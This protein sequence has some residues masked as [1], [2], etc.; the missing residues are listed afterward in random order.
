LLSDIVRVESHDERNSSTGSLKA[1]NTP[2]EEV[3]MGN[4]VFEIHCISG[5]VYYVGEDLDSSSSGRGSARPV[6]SG[7]GLELAKNWE[8]AIR[9]ARLPLSL[10]QTE[11]VTTNVPIQS[12][13]GNG[14]VKSSGS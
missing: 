6:Q 11:T 5:T 4:Y 10:S 14:Q 3:N 13:S 12:S 2:D 9:Q 1:C 7:T 8:S